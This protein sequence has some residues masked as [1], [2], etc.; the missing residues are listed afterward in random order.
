LG[1]KKKA[2]VGYYFFMLYIFEQISE[3][4]P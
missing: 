4:S 3:D 1:L 2:F